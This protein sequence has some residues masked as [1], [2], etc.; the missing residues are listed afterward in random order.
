[1]LTGFV[2]VLSSVSVHAD[3]NALINKVKSTWRAQDGETAEQII[4][5]VA[6]VAHFVPRGW[7]VGQKTDMSEPVFLSWAKH[8]GDKAD[9]E[10]TITWEVAPDGTMKVESPYAKPMELGWQAFALSLIA[11]EVDDGEKDV[12]R[13]FLH[14]PAN[15]NFVTTAQGKLGDLLR[16]G[17]C[18]IGDPV[19]VEYLPKVDEKQ[20]TKGELW[21]VQV[22]VNCDIPGPRYFTCDGIIVFEKPEGRDWEPQ[23]FFANRIATNAPGSWFDHADSKEKEIFDAARKAYEGAGIRGL[24]SPFPR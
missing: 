4:A 9:D 24:Q 2:L 7:E 14:N 12:N 5:K 16:R 19:G 10:Y 21:R 23:S 22:S 3:D 11:S 15:F 17:R 8:R 18:T 13:R 1:M 20:T 6:K